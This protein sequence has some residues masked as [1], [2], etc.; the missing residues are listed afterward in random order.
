M[1]C[2]TGLGIASVGAVPGEGLAFHEDAGNQGCKVTHAVAPLL[3]THGKYQQL[4]SGRLISTSVPHQN[5]RSNI[6]FLNCPKNLHDSSHCRCTGEKLIP[7]HQ[8][9]WG[10]GASFSE[11]PYVQSDHPSPQVTQGKQPSIPAGW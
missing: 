3:G 4:I 11:E 5:Q 9:L 7:Y 1:Y 2:S 10:T 8:C 6:D